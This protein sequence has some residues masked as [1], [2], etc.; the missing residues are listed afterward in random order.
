MKIGITDTTFARVD[1]AE[2]AIK[3][4]KENS[5]IEIVRYTVPGRDHLGTPLLGSSQV[6][7]IHERLFS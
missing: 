3:V 5:D 7:R 6:G 2:I 1:M 4:I